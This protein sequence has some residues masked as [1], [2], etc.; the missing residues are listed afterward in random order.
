MVMVTL[1]LTHNP[2][3]FL[4]CLWMFVL[5]CLVVTSMGGCPICVQWRYIQT[6]G[7]SRQE[8]AE[9]ER[10]KVVPYKDSLDFD[11]SGLLVRIVFSL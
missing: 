9:A 7:T 5:S 10:L 1:L 11:A 2:S 4:A 6:L 8:S 3:C